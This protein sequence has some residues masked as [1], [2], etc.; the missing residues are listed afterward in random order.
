MTA[1]YKFCWMMWIGGTALIVA[2]WSEV[3]SPTV[4]W[5][6]FGIALSGTV[7]SLVAQQHPQKSLRKPP[8]VGSE[9]Q[10]PSS[11]PGAVP[12]RPRE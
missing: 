11:E 7:L 3:V 6:G 4:G 10:T 8:E 1:M 9:V 12:V 2:S 5:V